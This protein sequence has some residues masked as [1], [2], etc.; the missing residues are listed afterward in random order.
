MYVKNRSSSNPPIPKRPLNPPPQNNNNLSELKP[1]S[2][3]PIKNNGVNSKQQIQKMNSEIQDLNKKIDLILE[4]LDQVLQDNKQLKLIIQHKNSSNNNTNNST[5]T[6]NNNL[7]LP[8]NS[9]NFLSKTPSPTNNKSMV[10]VNNQQMY[11][12]QYTS[13][14]SNQNTPIQNNPYNTIGHSQNNGIHVN[15]YAILG[16]GQLNNSQN[17]NNNQHQHTHSI[18]NTGN[19]HHNNSFGHHQTNSLGQQPTTNNGSMGHQNNIYYPNLPKKQES[20]ETNVGNINEEVVLAF[21]QNINPEDLKD[22]SEENDEQCIIPTK[23][24]F[25]GKYDQVILPV[26]IIPNELKFPFTN[27]YNFRDLGIAYKQDK[28]NIQIIPRK[29]F[30]GAVPMSASES[31]I[32]TFKEQIG[33]KTYIDL[34][35]KR[36]TGKNP[37]LSNLLNHKNKPTYHNIDLLSKNTTNIKVL[38]QAGG[39]KATTRL[40][41]QMVNRNTREEAVKNFATNIDGFTLYT[42]F[43]DSCGSKI[44]KA[45]R[46]FSNPDNFPIFFF[47]SHGRDRTGIVAALIFSICEFPKKFIAAEY[48]LS[49]YGGVDPNIAINLVNGFSSHTMLALLDYIEEKYSS[50]ENYL[51]L[52]KIDK[53]IRKQIRSNIL[54]NEF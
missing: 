44:A 18:G 51:D 40:I 50:V 39:I 20:Q 46:I 45:L 8:T 22:I 33:V 24:R 31:D 10:N 16:S 26:V 53:Y 37:F 6:N 28:T 38:L 13:N 5:I 35:S 15:P 41:G 43:V 12:N 11:N 42:I 36:E 4:K 49:E 21:V 29:V 54:K 30:R 14:G 48:F 19:N 25:H 32:L 34:R 47:C 2:N 27:V 1:I 3:L 17:I 9:N 52:I 7:Q 23:N